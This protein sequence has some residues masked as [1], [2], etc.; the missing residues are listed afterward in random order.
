M[1]RQPSAR[2][3]SNDLLG[4]CNCL[5]GMQ[6]GFSLFFW[7]LSKQS[8]PDK[9]L[10]A[11]VPITADMCCKLCSSVSCTINGANRCMLHPY[12]VA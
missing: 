4:R 10:A 8:R 12:S 7:W 1:A 3:S 6:H 2:M 5:E 11:G 9:L